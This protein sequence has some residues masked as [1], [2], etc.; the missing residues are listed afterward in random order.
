MTKNREIKLGNKKCSL[1]QDPLDINKVGHLTKDTCKSSD[2]G[3]WGG[4]EGREE[5][6][7]NISLK[8]Y[9]LA[10]QQDKFS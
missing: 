9:P 7:N 3:G 1:A 5:V 8:V 2:K 10:R 4:G 6:L